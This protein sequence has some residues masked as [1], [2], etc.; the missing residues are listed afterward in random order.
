MPKEVSLSWIEGRAWRA[1]S[2]GLEVIGDSQKE[3]GGEDRGMTPVEL[4]VAA[5]GLCTGIDLSFYC[6]RHGIDLSQVRINLT[7]EN[8]PDKP[9]RVG[10][11]RMHVT[12]PAGLTDAERATLT[13]IVSSCKVHNTLERGAEIPVTVEFTE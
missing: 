6:E 9:S 5:M 1:A 10:I 8:A 2:R 12:L 3:D 4:M 11:I 13:R 7:W